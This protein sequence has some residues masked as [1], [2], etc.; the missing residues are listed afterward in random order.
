MVDFV[1]VQENVAPIIGLET[2]IKEKF[3]I[4]PGLNTVNKIN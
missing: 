2:C 4:L 3:I 1:V